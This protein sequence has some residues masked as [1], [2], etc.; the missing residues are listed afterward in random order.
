M[1]YLRTLFAL[2]A[3]IEA[4]LCGGNSCSCPSAST[5]YKLREIERRRLIDE[6]SSRVAGKPAAKVRERHSHGLG[7]NRLPGSPVRPAA[8]RPPGHHPCPGLID[9]E[10]PVVR[11]RIVRALGFDG[12]DHKAIPRA[13]L[14]HRAAPGR[15]WHGSQVQ[16]AHSQRTPRG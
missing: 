5:F 14:G 15:V 1:V 13:T 6:E 2:I 12:R 9:K 11:P 8:H 16:G 7:D 3:C 4:S 10:P